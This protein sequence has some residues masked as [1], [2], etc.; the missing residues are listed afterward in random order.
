MTYSERI[1]ELREDKD[2][3]Q[4]RVARQLGI[5]QRTY[6]DYESNRIKLST[7]HLI[8]LAK[9]YDVDLNYLAG[10]SNVRN[11]FPKR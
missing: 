9:F 6:A 5:A 7:D 11:R 10:V 8:T 3:S 1:R 4:E 2:Y